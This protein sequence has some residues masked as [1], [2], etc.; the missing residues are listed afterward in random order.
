MN[1]EALLDA[2]GRYNVGRIQSFTRPHL[3]PTAEYRQLVSGEDQRT[4]SET[5]VG[6]KQ[7]RSGNGRTEG[8][9]IAVPPGA[10]DA[11]RVLARLGVT[12]PERARESDQDAMLLLAGRRCGK[13]A[14]AQEFIALDG[15]GDADVTG[16]LGTAAQDASEAAD[17]DGA[18][19]RQL[20]GQSHDDFERR[21]GLKSFWEM[22]IDAAGADFARL[23]FRLA[24]HQFVRPPD[25]ERQPHE[26]APR[27][28]SLVQSSHWTPPCEFIGSAR[29]DRD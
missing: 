26:K 12:T 5:A 16:I 15:R 27:Q 20:V 13:F 3:K 9:G 24:D 4:G 22:E 10:V 17:L 11:E 28:P 18:G 1:A 7:R 29:S 6:G 25:G 19:L 2:R 14:I 23:R 21:A 8:E